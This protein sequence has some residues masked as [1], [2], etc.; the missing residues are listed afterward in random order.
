MRNLTYKEAISEALLQGMA[1]DPNV[2]IFGLGVDDFKGIF[3]TTR[4]PFL[5][6]GPSRVF[7]TPASE[8]ALM[9]I[10]LGAALNGKRPVMVHAR[11][12]FMFLALDQLINNAAKWK[13]VYAGKSS[14]PIVVRGIVGQGWGQG[15]T[16]SQ[17]L[18]AVLA[19]FPGLTVAVPSTPHDIKGIILKSLQVD[20][21]VVIL[22]H[23]RLYDVLGDVPEHSYVMDFGQARVIR[24]G[25]DVTVVAT[26]LM[27]IEAVRAADIL[28]ENGI[29]VEVIDPVTLNPLDEETI[30]NSVEKTGRLICADS[31]WLKCSFAS[32]VAA[33]VAQK[34]FPA[35]K[36]PIKRIGWPPCPCPVSLALEREFYPGC[37][38]IVS[39]VSE[40][41]KKEFI[42]DPERF[43]FA[44]HFMGPY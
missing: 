35:L 13:Y 33:L 36:Q 40:L 41:L 6:F 21:P 38:A 29:S 42:I 16:H 26:S 37:R 34:A 1:R 28:Q 18:Q 20:F 8:N 3:G 39:A 2:F 31:D 11:N 5:K 44:D 19:H 22:E 27:V 4:E 12:D 25:H 10:A 24:E 23:R 15:A 43:Q 32:E 14:V 17:N 9:G 7:D 30:L